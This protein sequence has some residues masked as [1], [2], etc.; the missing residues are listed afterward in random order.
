[1]ECCH[2]VRAA[3][4]ASHREESCAEQQARYAADP[5]KYRGQNLRKF[6]PG[7]DWSEALTEYQRLFLLQKGCCAICG[8]SADQLGYN[9]HVDHNH[10]TGQVRGLLCKNCNHGLGLMKA[11]IDAK[12]LDSASEYIKLSSA[13]K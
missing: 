13:P 4:Y 6:W 2:I 12:L 3:E 11:D 5:I 9:L 7:T 1:M 8:I 10:I